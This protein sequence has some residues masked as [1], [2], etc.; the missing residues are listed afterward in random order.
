MNSVPHHE[1]HRLVRDLFEPVSALYWV[2]F[3]V[4]AFIG[5][6]AFIAAL[7]AVSTIVWGTL[8]VLSVLAL[9]RA[10][11]FTHEL[12]HLRREYLKVFRVV[13]DA[14]CGIPLLVPSFLYDGVHQEHHFRSNYGTTGD[15]EYLPF[16]RPPRTRIVFY[17]LSHFVLPPL[18]FVRFG[19]LG[20]LSWITQRSRVLV[21]RR[22]SS[23]SISPTYERTVPEKIPCSWIVQ[24]SLCTAY[25]WGMI[26]FLYWGLLPISFL[27]QLYFV[28]VAILMLNAIR[29]LAAHRY[30]NGGASMSF[31]E[32]LLDSVNIPSGSLLTPL[33]APVG[34]RYH[35]LH[36][37]FPAIPYHNLGKA[38]RRMVSEMSNDAVYQATIIPSVLQA[39]RELWWA[40]GQVSTPPR[41]GE[42]MTNH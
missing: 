19:I 11:L 40:S 1:R 5:W 33:I 4:S 15:G 6:A 22:L 42:T 14:L 10:V 38:H 18:I 2:D 32:Q 36:H 12:V 25:I 9:Y 24:E 39:L 8:V 28:S 3:T 30:A 35:A 17:L 27:L 13:W 7:F 16:G 20:P 34:L 37:L 26:A 21:W 23:L 41:R 31:E 29:T